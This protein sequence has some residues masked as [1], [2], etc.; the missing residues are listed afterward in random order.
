ML[1]EHRS[2][3]TSAPTFWPEHSLSSEKDIQSSNVKWEQIWPRSQIVSWS[4]EKVSPSNWSYPIFSRGERPSK[5]R[6]YATQNKTDWD[7]S[8]YIY[9]RYK[10]HNI[11]NRSRS[12]TAT[13]KVTS[14]YSTLTLKPTQGSKTA[15]V[16]VIDSYFYNALPLLI[17]RA[18]TFKAKFDLVQPIQV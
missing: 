15:H 17:K 5:F 12:L 10:C 6:D 11:F 3:D 16:C 2:N 9:Q 4:Q 18:R 8:L 13:E 7:R 14:V 1:R